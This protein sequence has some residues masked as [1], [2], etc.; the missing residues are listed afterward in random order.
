[1]LLATAEGRDPRQAASDLPPAARAVTSLDA[2]RLLFTAF[3]V[4][5]SDGPAPE[6]DET[7]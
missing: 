3:P 7:T 5:L 2:A 6:E 4:Q 1:M